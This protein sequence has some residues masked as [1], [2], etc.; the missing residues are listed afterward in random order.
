MFEHRLLS[1][2]EYVQG[3]LGLPSF[4]ITQIEMQI[5]ASNEGDYFRRHTDN[6]H[7][8]LVGRHLTYVYFFHR[9]PKRFRGGRLRLYDTSID[10]GQPVCGQASIDI[11][12]VQNSVVFFPSHMFH[13]VET[14]HCPTRDFVDSRFTINGWFRSK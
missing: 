1:V 13:E 12:P 7:A 10:A 14:V 8:L 5:T 3:A 4:P 9:E 6:T 2:V 11:E